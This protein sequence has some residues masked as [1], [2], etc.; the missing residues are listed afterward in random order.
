MKKTK[1]VNK[2][3]FI[4][5]ETLIV[6]VFIMGIFS[7]LYTNF[8]PLIGE[9]ERYKDYDTVESAYVAHW[10]RMVALKGLTDSSYNTAK[11]TG[12]IDISDCSLYTNSDAVAD[13]SSFMTMNNISKIYLTPYSTVE[14]KNYVKDNTSFSRSFREYISY[15]PTYSR[16][17]SKTPATGYYRV[18]VEYIS[19]DT[20]KYGNIELRNNV[21]SESTDKTLAEAVLENQGP[22]GGKNDD[23]TDTFITGSDP[24]NYV[25]YSGKLWRAVS[26][27]NE[28]KTTKLITQWN[29]SAL[30][31]S[32]AISYFTNSYIERWLN[33]TTVDGFLGNLRN[34]NDFIVN[35]A[36]WDLSASGTSF[37]DIEKPSFTTT[38]TAAVGLLNTYEY[39]MGNSSSTFDYLNNGLNWWTLTPMNNNNVQAINAFG[40]IS[41][42][43]PYNNYLGIRPVINIKENIKVV[44]G[45]GSRNNP[46]R[47]ENDNDSSLSGVRLNERYSG[48]YVRFGQ[49]SNTL[50]R[51]VSHEVAG[52]TKITSDQPLKNGNDVITSIFGSFSIFSKTN[53]IGTFLNGE[54]LTNY[55]G[56]TYE[57]MIED[58]TWYFGIIS[59]NGNYRK[60]KY[61]NDTGDTLTSRT[62]S[63][64]VGLLRFG[65]LMAGQFNNNANNTN[66]WLI[67]AIN[68]NENDPVGSAL[69]FNVRNDGSIYSDSYS[70]S[71][72]GIKPAIV[73]KSNVVIT[74]GDGTINNPFTISLG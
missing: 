44:S 21:S 29:V 39:K 19:N 73:L 59:A 66:Y 24:S 8:F 14:L 17:T 64:K 53:A 58:N 12:Y 56:N 26:V 69:V 18:I 63:A 35:S 61:A 49:G 13:C 9:Y 52:T 60:A 20:Y 34:Y 6:G 48:E 36:E 25:W 57:N 51:I 45:D 5:V 28:A 41:K 68:R 50:Y 38:E 15:L 3:G 43:S 74:G 71:A 2:S 23:G 33:D 65:E 40:Y 67:N 37:S 31:Y 55:V 70:T 10:G 46:Y 32:S 62:E 7:L 4:L 72:Y 30:N 22:N 42:Y 11:N 54:Y 1:I 27:N 47:L 16:N